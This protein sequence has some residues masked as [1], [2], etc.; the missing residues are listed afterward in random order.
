MKSI[1]F[2]IYRMPLY[3]VL[4]TMLCAAML[5]CVLAS[6]IQT[7]HKKFWRILNALL[8]LGECAAIVSRTLLYRNGSVSQLQL[9]PFYLFKEAQIQPEI[10]RSMLMN[11]FL[12]F[13]AGLTL[14]FILPDS[15]SNKSLITVAILLVFSTAIEGTQYIFQLGIAEIDDIICNVLGAFLGTMS[16][17]LSK[18]MKKG[19]FKFG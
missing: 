9:I 10:Y 13:P 17:Q 8:F 14:P 4:T 2:Y 19:K 18:W 16:F 7:K 15:I 1:M 12:F 6:I 3:K 5:W 11:V